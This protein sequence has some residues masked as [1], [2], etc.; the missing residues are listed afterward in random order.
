MT[1][2][3]YDASYKALVAVANEASERIEATLLLPQVRRG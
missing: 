1:P 3:Q 2:A